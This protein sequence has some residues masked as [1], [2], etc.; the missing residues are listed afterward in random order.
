MDLQIDFLYKSLYF[1]LT[2]FQMY[3]LGKIEIRNMKV[4]EPQRTEWGRMTIA[5]FQEKHEP[6]P[7][8]LDFPSVFL[9]WKWVKMWRRNLGYVKCM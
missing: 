1:S 9:F 3:L 5:V 2:L 6:K 7:K 8:T 4:W